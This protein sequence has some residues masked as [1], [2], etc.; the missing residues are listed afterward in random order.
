MFRLLALAFTLIGAL[1]MTTPDA[2]AGAAGAYDY[3]FTSIEGDPMPMSGFAG[4][5]VLVVNTASFCGFTHQYEGLQ[6]LWEKYRD[7]GLVVLGVPSNDFGR[8][9]PGTAT[10]IK[11]FCA[12]N[13]SIDFPMTEKYVV[14]GGEA[15]PFFKWA[16]DTLGAKAQPR[17]N[18]HKILIGPDG[19]ALDAFPSQTGPSSATLVSAVEAAL[20]N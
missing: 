6:S 18:F 8:Q 19:R 17:W 15:H 1:T 4:K 7:R 13:F 9:E 16:G 12:V 20:P 14:S 10:E 5:A 3:A 11:E 2:D